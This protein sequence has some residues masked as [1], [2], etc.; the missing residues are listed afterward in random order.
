MQ[1]GCALGVPANVSGCLLFP[2]M[3]LTHADDGAF[4]IVVRPRNQLGRLATRH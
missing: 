1:T 4:R 2:L 3:Q